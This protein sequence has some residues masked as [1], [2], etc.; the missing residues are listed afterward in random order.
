LLYSKTRTIII[1]ESMPPTAHDAVSIQISVIQKKNF[2]MKED[3][4]ER[5]INLN[6]K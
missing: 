1:Y 3:Q 2:F 4:H 5:L 6:Q